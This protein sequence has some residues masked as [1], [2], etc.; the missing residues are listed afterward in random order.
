MS[1]NPYKE[2]FMEG[3]EL[4]YFL[5]CELIALKEKNIEYVK[6]R[7]NEFT[8]Q[9]LGAQKYAWWLQSKISELKCLSTRG[10]F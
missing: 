9:V 8:Y 10:N 2:I 6:E 4:I 7:A 3:D 1:V 5:E